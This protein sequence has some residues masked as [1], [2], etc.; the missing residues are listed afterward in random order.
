MRN[1]KLIKFSCVLGKYNTLQ[2]KLEE[3]IIK[4]KK[5]NATEVRILLKKKKN[6]QTYKKKN[7]DIF[8]EIKNTCR[9]IYIY[10][11]FKI[12]NT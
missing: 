6:N 8:V 12:D 9:N 2:Q 5:K 3:Y 11:Y 7:Y 10:I 4:K 1:L